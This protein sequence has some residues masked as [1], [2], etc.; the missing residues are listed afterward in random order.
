MQV[1]KIFIAALATL[2]SIEASNSSSSSSSSSNGVMG[3]DAST[4]IVGAGL[5]A[6]GR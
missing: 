4:G 2:T 3:V 1:S 5:A 6:A